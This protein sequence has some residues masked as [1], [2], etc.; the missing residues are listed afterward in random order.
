MLVGLYQLVPSGSVVPKPQP[1][2][3]QYDFSTM[4][5][6]LRVQES[7]GRIFSMDIPVDI[8]FAPNQGPQLSFDYQLSPNS[9]FESRHIHDEYDE[10][11]KMRFY[12]GVLKK[13]IYSGG[14][15]SS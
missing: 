13:P 4:W 8:F 11:L 9:P 15:F 12:H 6:P 14:L 10:K 7:S 2:L 5:L 1:E 3:A